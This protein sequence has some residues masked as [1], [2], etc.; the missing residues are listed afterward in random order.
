[1]NSYS[2][3]CMTIVADNIEKIYGYLEKNLQNEMVCQPL[4]FCDEIQ[5]K[6]CTFLKCLFCIWFTMFFFFISSRFVFPFV[7]FPMTES[8][9]PNSPK[10]FRQWPVLTRISSAN[11]AR[12]LC[13]TSAISSLPTRLNRNLFKF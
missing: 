9:N 10:V 5:L 8:S 7:H 11:S 3:A 12:H 4:G 2:D 13:R 6:V 1:M